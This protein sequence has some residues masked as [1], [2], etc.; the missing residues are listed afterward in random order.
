[1]RTFTLFS[2][3]LLAI[4]SVSGHKYDGPVPKDKNGRPVTHQDPRIN[5][6]YTGAI[7]NPLFTPNLGKIVDAVLGTGSGKHGK[8][9]RRLTESTNS[10]PN[11]SLEDLEALAKNF[12]GIAPVPG[13]CGVK[14]KAYD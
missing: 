2:L 3:V 12:E 11:V 13:M 9:K 7:L 4:S 6:K 5:A 14:L 10:E 1:M 8:S